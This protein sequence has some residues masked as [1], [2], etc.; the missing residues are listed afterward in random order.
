MV[1]IESGDYLL[2][3]NDY[4]SVFRIRRY[5]DGPSSG[6]DPKDFPRDRD[7]WQL[8]RWRGHGGPEQLTTEAFDA[9]P[10]GWEEIATMLATRHDAITKAL[11]WEAMR[12]VGFGRVAPKSAS[13]NGRG[14][15]HG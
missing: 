3:S 6:L 9:F 12:G 11:R 2:P 15:G 8:W 4:E 5:V 13:R 10:S 1:R 7:Y 14:N